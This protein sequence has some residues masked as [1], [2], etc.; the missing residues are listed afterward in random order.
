MLPFGTIPSCYP[1]LL[2][3]KMANIILHIID[4]KRPSV[5]LMYGMNMYKNNMGTYGNSST[6]DVYL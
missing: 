4:S 3:N 5:Q 6:H 1:L 2:K